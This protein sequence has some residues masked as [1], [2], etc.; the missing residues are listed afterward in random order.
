MEKHTAG[1]AAT[2]A[3]GGNDNETTGN[4]LGSRG[5]ADF[6]LTKEERTDG[7]LIIKPRGTIGRY[8]D[9]GIASQVRLIVGHGSMFERGWP[10]TKCRES[11]GG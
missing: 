2:L 9:A 10:G 11:A 8:R 5:I 1:Q 7:E 4:K 6:Q 3:R